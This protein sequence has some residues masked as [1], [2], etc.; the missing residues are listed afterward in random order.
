M[1]SPFT[2]W[3]FLMNVKPV[4][5]QHCA[6]RDR[7]VP[8][9]LG[10]LQPLLIVL[11]A[12]VLVLNTVGLQRDGAVAAAEPLSPWRYGRAQTKI[13]PTQPMWMSGYG[14]RDRVAEGT[15]TELW[16]KALVL[17]PEEGSAVVL[18]TLDIVGIDGTLSETI[19]RQ[20]AEAHGLAV[21]C[22]VLCC[23]HTHT[24]PVIGK[25]LAPLHYL[26]VNEEEQA[27]IDAYAARLQTQVVELAHEAMDNL[28][29]GTLSWGN[30]TCDIAVNRRNN[31][32]AMVP[33]IRTRGALMGPVDHDVPVL[34]VKAADESVEAVVFGYACHATVL[35]FYQ[36]SGDYP[37][38]AQIALESRMPGVQAMFWAGCGGDQN[39][40]PRRQVELARH[41]GERL[42]LAVES[43][44]RT[45]QLHSLDSL[46][47]TQATAVRLPFV[48]VPEAS[49]LKEQSRSKDR[50]EKARAE[51]L[52]EIIEQQ[53]QSLDAYPYPV[54]TW[55][56]GSQVEW[57]FLGG[58][59]VVDYALRIKQENQAEA[60]WVAGYSNDVMAYIPSRRVLQEGGY[61][62]A[63]AMV[64]YGLPSPWHETVEKRIMDEVNTQLSKFNQPND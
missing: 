2:E 4:L 51:W 8:G 64:Y 57:V 19:R 25:N 15:L 28:Q 63:G 53:G 5:F 55:K 62:G 22:V 32:E 13:T 23:S 59:V 39:P 40:L 16:A 33:E 54:V 14:G 1:S 41:Y 11:C 12:V 56:L 26:Q 61:E 34:V 43:V 24:G 18:I 20:I 21:D 44:I 7:S 9:H 29:T 50:Y 42:A 30:A 49:E 35:S 6:F 45:R 47:Q 38:Y 27:K 31:R 36:W 48:T 10:M 60:T 52:L 58:E 37:G 3:K 46:I 17:Q